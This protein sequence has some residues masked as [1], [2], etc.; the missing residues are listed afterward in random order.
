[1]LLRTKLTYQRQH[2]K[3]L[4]TRPMCVTLETRQTSSPQGPQYHTDA[5]EWRMFVQSK[6]GSAAT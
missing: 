3:R 4:Y 1:M 6:S 2:A 5:V